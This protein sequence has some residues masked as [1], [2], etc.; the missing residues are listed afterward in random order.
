MTSLLEWVAFAIGF[1]VIAYAIGAIVHI[2]IDQVHG[3]RLVDRY[4]RTTREQI[5][6]PLRAELI[7]KIDAIKP[8]DLAPLRADLVNVREMID[9][10]PIEAQLHAFLRSEDGKQWAVELADVVTTQV[11][12]SMVAK[13]TSAAG[14][15]ARTAQQKIFNAIDGSL[16]FGNPIVNGLWTSIPRENKV[17]FYNVIARTLRRAGLVLVPNSELES[18]PMQLEGEF[19]EIEGAD[20]GEQVDAATLALYR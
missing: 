7:Q 18:E 8:P 12:D 6:E 17:R 16:D 14:A 3:A 5:I 15:V 10:L 9:S 1:P 2:W 4:F 13:T 19:T 11:T 20:Q